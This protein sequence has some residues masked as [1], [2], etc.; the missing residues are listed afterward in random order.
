MENNS[1]EFISKVYVKG[2]SKHP[3]L[4]VA[5]KVIL[6]LY[7]LI[8]LFVVTMDGFSFDLIKDNII[9]IILILNAYNVTKPQEGFKDTVVK[10]DFNIDEMIIKYDSINRHDKMGPRM[11][12]IT[13]KYNNITKLEYNKE[14]DGL[15]IQGYPIERV[16][17]LKEGNQKE[18]II[19]YLEKNQE[20]STIIYF[21]SDEKNKIL[22][23]LREKTN[24]EVIELN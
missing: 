5:V 3:K 24:I 16:R 12:V 17:Y 7:A 18:Y 4:R 11:E 8:F 22:N 9:P 20:K 23:V 6:I 2:K 1:L 14:V 10:V 15:N 21:S 13:I 19:N